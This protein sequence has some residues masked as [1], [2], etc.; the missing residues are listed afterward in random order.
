L[1]EQ[2]RIFDHAASDPGLELAEIVFTITRNTSAGG[3]E[4]RLT[5]IQN[6]DLNSNPPTFRVTGDTTKNTI[7]PRIIPLNA[8]ALAAFQQAVNRAAR[9]GSHLPE[10][11]IFPLTVNRALHDPNR[12]ASRSWLRKQTVLLRER[13][14][15]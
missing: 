12:P 6:L 5:R 1:E 9:L 3:S 14:V 4:L 15:R 8:D 13:T 7:R 10:H 11:Y 2:Q